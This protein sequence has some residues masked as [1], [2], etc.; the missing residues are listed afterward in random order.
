MNYQIENVD[1][2]ETKTVQRKGRKSIYEPLSQ[3][4]KL[5][6]ESECIVI[7]CKENQECNTL[8]NSVTQSLKKYMSKENFIAK[9]LTTNDGIA[10]FKT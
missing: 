9:I 8:K 10:I 2:V 1:N 5:L 3:Q 4:I 6:Q 7:K